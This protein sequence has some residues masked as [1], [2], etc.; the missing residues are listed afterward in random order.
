MPRDSPD[1]LQTSEQGWKGLFDDVEV[2]LGD[3]LELSVEGRKE[4]YDFRKSILTTAR[5]YENINF[6]S[7]TTTTTTIILT[8]TMKRKP[9][10][11][12]EW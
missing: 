5:L 9:G 4:L 8:L 3:V 7:R 6:K 10:R 1:K 11:R 2:T 12:R